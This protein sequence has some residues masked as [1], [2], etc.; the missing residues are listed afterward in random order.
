MNAI[1]LFT[2]NYVNADC[3]YTISSGGDLQSYL[4]DQVRATQWSSSGSNDATQE[5][6]E[7]IFKNWQGTE[8][9]RTIDRL[10]LLNNN[11][12]AGGADYW[13]GSAWVAISDAT[14]TANASA[15]LVIDLSTPVSTSRLRLRLDTTMTT[16]A[17][18][19]IGEFKAC[20][21]IFSGS[22]QWLSDLRREDEQKSGNYRL[23][24]GS[25]V[26]WREYAKFGATL[27]LMDVSKANRDTLMPYL[28]AGGWLTLV[29]AYDHDPAAIYEVA[30]VSAPQEALDRKAGTYEIS[31]ELKGR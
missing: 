8:V 15:D 1:R 22:Q 25:L 2:E 23:A 16:N 10:I 11:I 31:L 27:T 29:V 9:S 26:Q 21:S 18:K 30:V 5:T 3:A 28:T 13:D 24:G 14:L 12:K 17:E 7:V 19:V 4:Y 6:I 20:A